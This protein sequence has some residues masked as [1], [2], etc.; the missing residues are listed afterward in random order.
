ME[1]F[2]NGFVSWTETH[3]LITE[4]IVLQ[5]AKF[6]DDVMNKYDYSTD[7]IKQAFSTQ[8]T[9]GLW[10]LSTDWTNEF[11][12]KYENENWEEKDFYETVDAFCE[13]KNTL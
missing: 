6:I 4:F 2:V 10:Q 7:A 1:N 13:M 8:G 3:F 5:R 11:E 9:T 12:K